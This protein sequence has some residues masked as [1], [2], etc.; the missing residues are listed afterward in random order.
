MAYPEFPEKPEE[1]L[2]I[3]DFLAQQNSA[4]PSVGAQPPVVDPSK[5][6]GPATPPPTQRVS[7]DQLTGQKTNQPLPNP[8]KSFSEKLS[9]KATQAAQN[10]R[11][12]LTGNVKDRLSE[13]SAGQAVN[14]ARELKQKAQDIAANVQS[15]TA[16]IASGGLDARAWIAVL[17]KNSKVVL[18]IGLLA[19]AGGLGTG[20]LIGTILG[21]LNGD[22]A[23][24]VGIPANSVY[25]NS[26]GNPDGIYLN[27]MTPTLTV[28]EKNGKSTTIGLESTSGGFSKETDAQ[29][30]TSQNA[31]GLTDDYGKSIV[32]QVCLFR[33]GGFVSENGRSGIDC[34]TH[35][36]VY[37]PA[38]G[39]YR[40][41][42]NEQAEWY[43]T[44][45]WPYAKSYWEGRTTSNPSSPARLYVGR[46]IVIY[47]PGT[48]KAVVGIAAEWGPQPR[49]T[50]S[51]NAAQQ[52]LWKY[53]PQG[54]EP[55]TQVPQGYL[56]LVAGGGT[57]IRQA[58]GTDSATPIVY[59][60]LRAD[61]QD[62]TPLG[63]IT[64]FVVSRKSGSAS[65]TGKLPSILQDDYPDVPY[66]RPGDTTRTISTSGC[67][68][69]SAAMIL[70]GAGIGTSDSELVRELAQFSLANGHRVSAGTAY[71]FFPAVAEKYGLREKELSANDWSGIVAEL[72]LGHSVIISGKGPKGVAPF[73]SNGHFVVLTGISADG[74]SVNVQDPKRRRT[75]SVYTIPTSQVTRGITSARSLWK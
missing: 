1:G 42:T 7:T 30:A 54:P 4:T 16:L 63:P 70:R 32:G 75:G 22:R 28:K 23:G 26:P 59:G 67:G 47:N 65:T 33:D 38:T 9:G 5:P 41:M 57:K 11:N 40:T 73:T 72:R 64:S 68:V 6:S 60:F 55:R 39:E 66:P 2:S 36:Q 43:V 18:G 53:G 71:S 8:A 69:V 12:A 56:G 21:A 74:Q 24:D 29:L 37:N 31:G 44:A 50:I 46:K 61:L 14:R 15:I 62:S 19:F 34:I 25:A 20:L 49:A 10:A 48:G 35:D 45:R 58:L 27:I 3:N 52:A 17:R 13:T 51:K